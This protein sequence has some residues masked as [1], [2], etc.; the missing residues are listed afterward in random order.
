MDEVPADRRDIITHGRRPGM[1]S[2]IAGHP[3][4]RLTTSSRLH[5]RAMHKAYI[6]RLEQETKNKILREQVMA[7]KKIAVIVGSLRKNPSI[8]KWAR[9]L[10]H[11]PLNH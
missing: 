6:S 1:L 10:Q 7:K 8:G 9:R 11:L 5:H 2:L 3:G 4:N